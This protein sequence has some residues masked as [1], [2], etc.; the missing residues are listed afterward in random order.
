M[1]L[2]QGKLAALWGENDKVMLVVGGESEMKPRVRAAC[3]KL[4]Y[5]DGGNE[6]VDSLSLNSICSILMYEINS[7]IG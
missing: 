6:V 3:Q 5:V 4:V 2:A 1:A 7:A